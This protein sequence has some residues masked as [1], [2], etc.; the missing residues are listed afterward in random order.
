MLDNLNGETPANYFSRF[1]RVL[2]AARKDG[3]FK[4]S[5]AADLASKS[6]SNKKVKDILTA[7]EYTKLM[8]APC[9]NHEVKKAF[10]F[11]LYTGFRWADVKPLTWE[12]IKKDTVVEIKQKKTGELLEIPLHPIALQILGERKTGL[13]FKL[14]TPDGANK[15]LSKWCDAAGLGKHITWHCARHSFSVLLQD[16][17]TDV[18]TVAG[19]L[20]HTSTKYVHKTYKRYRKE[21]AEAAIFRLPS[22]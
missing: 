10:V 13:V 9:L 2:E 5:P 17:G 6:K 22:L 8:S 3:Y 11:S 14:P 12:N 18:A 20:G 1:K 4:V 15:I 19:M 16:K 21:N 7:D